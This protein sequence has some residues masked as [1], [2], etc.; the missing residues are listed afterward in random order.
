MSD[1]KLCAAEISFKAGGGENA[2]SCD[3]WSSSFAHLS[4]APTGLVSQE[5]ILVCSNEARGHGGRLCP[6]PPSDMAGSRVLCRGQL[7]SDPN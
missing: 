6:S 1:Q 7:L 2:L 4:L 5:R 3:L